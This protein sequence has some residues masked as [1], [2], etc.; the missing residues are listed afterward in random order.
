VFQPHLRAENSRVKSLKD[1]PVG[2]FQKIQNEP[3]RKNMRKRLLGKGL[4]APSLI[5]ILSACSGGGGGG[6]S[7]SRATPTYVKSAKI[8]CGTKDCI[9]GASVSGFSAKAFGIDIMSSTWGDSALSGFKSQYGAAKLIVANTNSIVEQLNL[10]AEDNSITSCDDIPTTGNFTFGG[11]D[12]ELGGHF[13]DFNIGGGN[14]STDHSLKGSNASGDKILISFKCGTTQSIHIISKGNAGGLDEVF[15]SVNTATN[16]ITILYGEV[17]SGLSSYGYFK[18]DGGDSFTFGLFQNNAAGTAPGAYLA[19]TKNYTSHTGLTMPA[20]DYLEIG[21]TGVAHE[22]V[23]DMGTF[24][25][26]SNHYRGCVEDYR[27]GSFI[28]NDSGCAYITNPVDNGNDDS[29]FSVSDFPSNLI[30]NA[31]AWTTDDV[32]ALSITDPDD[33]DIN[34]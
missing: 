19:G 7:S 5:L 18:N 9:S 3:L 20:S 23:E 14:V 28:T 6:S 15:Y 34:P 29:S 25:G 26:D 2:D 31:T 17:L 13:D 11:W 21:W 1:S 4:L 27:T 10:M 8:Q 30:G 24:G 16:A 33:L 22:E 32:K 12:Y